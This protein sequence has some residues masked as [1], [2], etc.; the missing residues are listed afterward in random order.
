MILYFTGTGNSRYIA[1]RMKE[2]TSD[3]MICINDRIKR[4]DTGSIAVSGDL[5]I[6]TPT[7][8]WQIPTLVKEWLLQTTFVDVEHVWF[9]MNCGDSIG[10]AD[11]HNQELCVKKNWT[12]MGTEQ[13]VMPENYIVMFPV[14]DEKEAGKIIEA[15][16]PAIE[17]A[18]SCIQMTKK[19]PDRKGHF[20]DGLLSGLVNRLFY[21]L[22]VKATPFY[23]K[24]SCIGCGKCVSLCPLNNIR[25][26]KEK[27]IWGSECTHCMA[28]ICSCPKEAIEYGKKSKGKPRYY[29]K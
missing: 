6:V 17:Q 7:Y 21:P 3:D 10:K 15:A 16:E 8:A 5:I 2:K 18:I 22:F 13:I 27:P 9:V 23:V 26:E 20:W 11:R 12:Y 14:P 25:L 4:K 24:D 29:C 1:K 28:C 19:F